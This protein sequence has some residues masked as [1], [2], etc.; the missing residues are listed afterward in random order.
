MLPKAVPEDVF[1]ETD[2]QWRDKDNKI[3]NGEVDDAQR[4]DDY[5]PKVEKNVDSNDEE[6][7]EGEPEDDS[8][9]EVLMRE[10]SDYSS[11]SENESSQNGESDGSTKKKG[12][13][14]RRSRNRSSYET[15]VNTIAVLVVVCWMMRVPVMYRD[16]TK[17]VCLF[18]WSTIN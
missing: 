13:L 16:F 4:E 2:Q 1:Q 10:N 3:I 11:S 7:D 5:R 12:Q 9:L 14:K 17:C 6:E 15:P 8:E 18:R